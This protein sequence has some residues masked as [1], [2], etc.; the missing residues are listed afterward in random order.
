MEDLPAVLLHK[1][2]SRD[3]AVQEQTTQDSP[4][5][6]PL[7]LEASFSLLLH[8]DT[9]CLR[10]YFLCFG[11]CFLFPS[12]MIFTCVSMSLLPLIVLTRGP[13]AHLCKQPLSPFVCVTPSTVHL[14]LPCLVM[15]F[16]LDHF[17]FWYL[18]RY[19]DTFGF[20]CFLTCTSLCLLGPSLTSSP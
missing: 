10:M 2:W 20:L 6:Q 8:S 11:S 4:G 9:L 12:L 7:S 19:E 16:M 17:W 13:P 3:E 14:N 18:L 1:H 15:S 5:L